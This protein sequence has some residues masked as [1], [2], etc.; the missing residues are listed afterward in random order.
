MHY[1]ILEIHMWSLFLPLK[2]LKTPYPAK[3]RLYT[4]YWYMKTQVM[5]IS[6]TR[7]SRNKEL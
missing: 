1:S 7:S 3:Q 5:I 4:L 6:D 2:E